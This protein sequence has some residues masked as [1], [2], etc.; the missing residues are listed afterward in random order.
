MASPME[1]IR[2]QAGND[3]LCVKVIMPQHS[4]IFFMSSI[5]LT[6]FFNKNNK[7]KG[8]MKGKHTHKI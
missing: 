7:K 1:A 2:F 8:K 5:R 6:Q 4:G 3:P